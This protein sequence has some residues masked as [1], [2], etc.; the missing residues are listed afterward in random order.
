MSHQIAGRMRRTRNQAVKG[1]YRKPGTGCIT[2]PGDYLWEGRY[3]PKIDGKRFA[4]N[5]CAPTEEECGQKLAVL[6]AEMK[7]ELAPL[8]PKQK[9]G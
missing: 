5:V 6:I 9:A 4:R 3:S 7:K 2:R 8:R 1:K